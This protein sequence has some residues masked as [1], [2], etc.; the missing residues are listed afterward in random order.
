MDSRLKSPHGEPWEPAVLLLVGLIVAQNS[1][2]THVL[3]ADIVSAVKKNL[4]E[5]SVMCPAALDVLAVLVNAWEDEA[6]NLTTIFVKQLR[7]LTNEKADDNV[8][9]HAAQCLTAVNSCPAVNAAV[10]VAGATYEARM[11]T[12]ISLLSSSQSNVREEAAKA[13]AAILI[14]GSAGAASSASPA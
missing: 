10:T 1:K 5:S 9:L 3:H 11:H 14:H 13:L 2:D 6:A 8:R 4:K 7:A 12:A